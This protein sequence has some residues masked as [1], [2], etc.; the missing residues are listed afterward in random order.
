MIIKRRQPSFEL[1]A[2]VGPTSTLKGSLVSDGEK[3]RLKAMESSKQW[4][5]IVV[6]R[7]QAEFGAE[8]Q[9]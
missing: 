8:L 4:L 5:D 1:V 9:A 3:E 2:Q 6:A 7:P